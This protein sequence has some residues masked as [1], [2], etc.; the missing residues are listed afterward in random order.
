MKRN[1][2]TTSHEKI[3]WHCFSNLLF[4]NCI[5]LG[6]SS[7]NISSIIR[8]LKLKGVPKYKQVWTWHT[9][10]FVLCFWLVQNYTNICFRNISSA[11]VKWKKCTR[12]IEH[13]CF[14]CIGWLKLDFI[15][16]FPWF[17]FLVG[18][19]LANYC[20][21]LSYLKN[22]KIVMPVTFALLVIYFTTSI[23]IKILARVTRS[24]FPCKTSFPAKPVSLQN[25]F[26]C[27]TS[28]PAKTVSLRN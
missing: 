12:R 4:V 5:A 17:M 22:H 8:D 27:K 13:D 18:V 28:F 14:F 11:N 19:F 20:H 1:R 24:K 25:Q 26:P 15:L 16:N 3:F 7:L 23:M 2:A 10:I 6:Y 21:L 9:Y